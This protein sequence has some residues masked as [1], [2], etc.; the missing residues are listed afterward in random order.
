MA[1]SLFLH[2]ATNEVDHDGRPRRKIKRRSG[3][4]IW[5]HHGCSLRR[6]AFAQRTHVLR[7]ADG[8]GGRR[9]RSAPRRRCRSDGAP[10]L[11]SRT[12]RRSPRSARPHFGRVR[13]RARLNVVFFA[14]SVRIPG[15][16][17]VRVRGPAQQRHACPAT[18]ATAD[19]APSRRPRSRFTVLASRTRRAPA[20][21]VPSARTTWSA[22]LATLVTRRRRG[23]SFS[24]RASDGANR[25]PRDRSRRPG[26]K[27]SSGGVTTSARR[28]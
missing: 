24:S 27:A 17:L 7:R 1:A 12:R 19:V 3:A 14:A 6:L 11:R 16:P 21:G 28:R 26:R 15:P 8:L 23:R 25:A 22:M 20:P 5:L 10:P 4:I 9:R 18:L 13:R 2:P